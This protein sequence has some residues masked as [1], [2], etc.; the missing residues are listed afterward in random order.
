[1][2]P[3]SHKYFSY[4]FKPGNPF[5]SLLLFITTLPLRLLPTPLSRQPPFFLS[6][7]HESINSVLLL[8]TTYIHTIYMKVGMY[9][10][11]AIYQ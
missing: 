8:P 10:I 5:F 6:I 9:S 2:K 11:Y 4:L 7:L 1:M 3:V